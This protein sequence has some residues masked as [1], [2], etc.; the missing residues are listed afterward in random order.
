MILPFSFFTKGFSLFV[1]QN[2]NLSVC[3]LVGSLK[4]V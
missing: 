2:V 1:K 4:G 3:Y